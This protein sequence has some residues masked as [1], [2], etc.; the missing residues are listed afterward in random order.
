MKHLLL[1]FSFM[2]TLQMGFA[3][4]RIDYSN[5]QQTL[6]E[7]FQYVNMEALAQ[8]WQLQPNDQSMVQGTAL[9]TPSQVSLLPQ[10]GIRLTATP[11]DNF[12]TA[13]EPKGNDIFYKS[14]M[15]S[16]KLDQNY[17]IYRILVKM[18]N[19]QAD[20]ND[21]W[22]VFKLVGKNV[23]LNIFDGQYNINDNL[24][25]NISTKT[26]ETTRF[27]C[28]N[29]WD[30]E[31]FHKGWDN[32]FY[33]FQ[34]VW[35]PDAIT[36]LIHG[37]EVAT[38]KA[39][40]LAAPMESLSLVVALQTNAV[41]NQP[42]HMDIKSVSVFTHKEGQPYTYMANRSWE[43]H[44][45]TS[46]LF[47][48]KVLAQNGAILPNPNNT[49]EVFYIGQDH[50]LYLAKMDNNTWKSEQIS[51]QVID[52]SLTYVKTTNSVLFKNQ[53][54]YLSGLTR[55]GDTFHA[56]VKQNIK[57]ANHPQTLA[58]T[59]QGN[60]I[61]ILTNGKI[62]A[63]DTDLSL[64]AMANID[65]IGD[66]TITD[67]ETILYKGENNQLKAVKHQGLSFQNVALPFIQ[68]SSGM[69]SILFHTYK[70]KQ[71]IAF[72]G[73]DNKFHLLEKISDEQY[74]HS[75][76]TYNYEL[77][78]P[79]HPDY[80]ASNLAGGPQD[81]FYL[82]EDGRL[83]LFGWNNTRTQREHFWVDDNFFTQDYLADMSAPSLSFGANGQLFYRTK[84]GT[85]GYFQ[86]ENSTKGCDCQTIHDGQNQNLDL[87]V[88]TS[89]EAFPNPTMGQ[90]KMTINHFCSSCTY[91]YE[92]VAANGQRISTGTFEG[93][94][95]TINF[96]NQ[97]A[98]V[99]QLNISSETDQFTK[100]IVKMK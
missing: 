26:N 53:N 80:I 88:T 77:Q 62:A 95:H 71:G 74:R 51:D 29:N 6:N 33:V 44:H 82:S 28:G 1:A 84:E 79:N 99:Y 30:L 5:Y 63:L 55:V 85:L 48:T 52:G 4:S 12:L 92:L 47:E 18:P 25:Q 45:A 11:L 9:F 97:P 57:L 38:V 7:Q 87:S 73:L 76:P 78:D 66:L 68:L 65:Y 56:F 43:F 32:G 46:S 72:R 86:W 70:D 90:L 3:Q 89:I 22:P 91:N 81:I 34:A 20:I 64:T 49:N 96:E 58:S 16:K 94:E 41:S 19:G 35:T 13:R 60:I 42:I 36:F 39:D 37:R 23:V 67:D 100:R 83:Q 59:K 17:G 8:N 15:I 61:A 2:L 98:G 14:G 93:N 50:H 31:D 10:G 27:Q 75:I 40:Q 21:A 69:G 54:G 24:S